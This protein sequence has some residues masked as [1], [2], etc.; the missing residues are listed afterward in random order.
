[1]IFLLRSRNLDL[2]L[3]RL[4]KVLFKYFFI[5]FY[6][7]DSCFKYLKKLWLEILKLRL[8][9]SRVFFELNMFGECK[10]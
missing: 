7:V 6:F 10:N 4:F 3:E 2:I 1:M 5:L 8:I 9:Y